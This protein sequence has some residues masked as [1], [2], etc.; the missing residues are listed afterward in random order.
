MCASELTIFSKRGTILET[1]GAPPAT[2][3]TPATPNTEASPGARPAKRIVLED[4]LILFN[5]EDRASLLRFDR[6]ET[7]LPTT[8][9][10]KDVPVDLVATLPFRN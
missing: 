5:S 9:P 1:A 8:R 7:P 2:P 4:G 3:A 10:E 6:L